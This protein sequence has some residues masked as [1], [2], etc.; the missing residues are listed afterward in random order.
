V[1]ETRRACEAVMRVGVQMVRKPEEVRPI[2]GGLHQRRP[3]SASW[4]PYDLGD[5]RHKGPLDLVQLAKRIANIVT[6]K[7]RMEETRTSGGGN[8]RSISMAISFLSAEA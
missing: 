1:R 8:L 5:N 4:L 6:A 2:R 3:P 7:F